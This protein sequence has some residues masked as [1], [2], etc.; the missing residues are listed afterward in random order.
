MSEGKIEWCKSKEEFERE[1]MKMVERLI[2]TK[3][4]H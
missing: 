4:K 1:T 2:K 3:Q